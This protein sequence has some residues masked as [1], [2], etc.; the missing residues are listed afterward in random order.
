[1][2]F[3]N[4]MTRN[5]TNHTTMLATIALNFIYMNLDKSWSLLLNLPSSCTSIYFLSFVIPGVGNEYYLVSDPNEVL[6]IV[7]QTLPLLSKMRVSEIFSNI[8]NTSS[9]RHDIFCLFIHLLWINNL[10]FINFS[11]SQKVHFY[12]VNSA[13]HKDPFSMQA[14]QINF[15]L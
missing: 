15:G 6:E 12:Y 2:S 7:R 10:F 11:S 9:Y 5:S 3:L 13:C 8:Q 4:R 14:L 1:M